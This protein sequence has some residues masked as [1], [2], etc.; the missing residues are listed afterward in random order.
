VN[1]LAAY[2]EIN[3]DVRIFQKPNKILLMGNPNV[4]KSVIF[5][6]LTGIRV[7]S[8]NF[9]GTTV[10][11]TEGTIQLGGKAYHLI[12]VPGTY[13]ME[14][15]SE[16]EAVAV[17]FMNS[18][19]TA[20]LCV[21]DATNLERNIK[22]GLELQKYNVP[23]IYILNLVD[24]AKRHGVEINVELLTKELGAPV[25]PTVAVKGEGIY[26]IKEELQRILSNPKDNRCGSCSFCPDSKGNERDVWDRAREIAARVRIT[27]DGKLSFLDRLGRNMLKPWP[28]IPIAFL[29]ILL[30]LGVIVGGGKALRAVLL[31]PLVNDALVPSFKAIFSSFVPEGILLNVLIGEYGIFVIGFE[32]IIALILPY[33]FLFYIVFS[34]LEDS[35]VLPRLSVLFDNIMRKMGV[36][37]G[38][39]I[40]ILMGYGCAVP[41]II[42]SRT[43]TTRKERL[44]ISTVVCFSV[45]C[46]SQTGA[47]ISLFAGFSPLLLILMILLSLT[48]MV[49]VSSILGRLLKGKVEPMVIEIP[50]LLM[51]N[52]GAYFKKLMIRMKHFLVEAETP[53]LISILIAALL[54]ETGLLNYIAV[55]LEPI[56]SGWLGLPK[57]AVIALILGIVR[58][59]M[60]VAPLL[61]IEG[62]T[63]L[64][65]FVGGTVS[66]LYL[67]CLSVFGILSK[68]FNAKVAVAIGL[69]TFVT[70]FIVA[71]L[72]NQIAH[73]FM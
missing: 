57:D 25:I 65:A 40:T 32:W 4:G 3:D 33:V 12:D 18:N 60:A 23:I 62:L 7:V 5:S 17:R 16:A 54:K 21:L 42:G 41:A 30:S 50:N 49:I 55:F 70:A 2:H 63:A 29:I 11:Y 66:L 19:P 59:E 45:P 58:R 56:V 68:E 61:A 52:A 44:I 20:V 39:M 72:I 27:M 9:A 34:F 53:M 47:L 35:G 37:G 13:S 64:Q 48:I 38:S 36:Q 71:G 8:S 28:G 15:T 24:V 1:D 14:A 6:E 46:I 73:L 69:S 43:A 26:G 22:L 31:L 67:P 51:P 10:T